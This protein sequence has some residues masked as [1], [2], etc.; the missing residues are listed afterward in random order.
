MLI[1]ALCAAADLVIPRHCI[2]C[3]RAGRTLCSSCAPA[4]R[5]RIEAGGLSVVAAAAYD[6]A[7]RAALIAYKERARRDLAGPLGELL[8]R[9]V[10]CGSAGVL[11]PV[12]SAARVARSRGGD[13]VLRLARVAAR[14]A[15][16]NG[17]RRVVTPLRLMRS[18]QD[19]AGLGARE[20]AANLRGAMTAMPAPQPG[21]SVII[22]DDIVTTGATMREAARALEGAGW[23]VIG[24]A[25]VA[26]TARRGDAGSYARSA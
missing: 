22:V 26:A 9:A 7:T 12:P 24:A 13:H 14:I 4:G 17:E 1:P 10:S 18:V 6:G 8:A 11:V 16:R 3:G 5:I 25:V 19:S 15:A 21:T 2:A 20:R 23:S